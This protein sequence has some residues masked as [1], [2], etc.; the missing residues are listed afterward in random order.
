M[1]HIAAEELREHE[2]H[3]QQHHERREQTPH[4]AED[5]TLV[6]LFEVAFHQFL[7]KELVTLEFVQN[8]LNISL[9]VL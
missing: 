6:F 7:E 8:H 4:R 1:I 3:D 5:C 2:P 9:R